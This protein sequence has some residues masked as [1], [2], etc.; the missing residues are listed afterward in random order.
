MPEDE[1]EELREV[2]HDAL[3]FARTKDNTNTIFLNKDK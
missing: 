3:A 2:N 1:I